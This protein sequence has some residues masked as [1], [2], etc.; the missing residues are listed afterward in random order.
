G[1]HQRLIFEELIDMAHPRFLEIADGLGDE[2]IAEMALPM[3]RVSHR[4]VSA[5]APM[6]ESGVATVAGTPRDSTPR[7]HTPP[8]TPWPTRHA[9]HAPAGLRRAARTTTGWPHPRGRSGTDVARAG[10]PGRWRR[11]SS[12]CHSDA[13][14][15]TIHPAPWCASPG[16][17]SATT[18]VS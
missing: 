17:T 12:V 15:P 16:P 4:S 6:S 10:T 8:P 5:G 18:R 2:G 9:P 1:V 11:R 7:S 14:S 3:P 13:R